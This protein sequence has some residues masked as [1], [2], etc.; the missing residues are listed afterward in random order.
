MRLITLLSGMAK[1]KLYG[2]LA[3]TTTVGICAF[4]GEGDDK[5]TSKLVKTIVA[6]FI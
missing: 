6:L 2:E 1:L 3:M 4:S 5:T